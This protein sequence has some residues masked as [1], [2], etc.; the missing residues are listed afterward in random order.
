MNKGNIIIMMI[1]L[2]GAFAGATTIRDTV[3]S[4]TGGLSVEGDINVTDAIRV[5]GSLVCL[6][7]GQYC[8]VFDYVTI[9]TWTYQYMPVFGLNSTLSNSLMTS[10]ATEIT[11]SDLHITSDGKI[12]Y[13]TNS[14]D[15]EVH[16]VDPDEPSI[17]LEDEGQERWEWRATANG[18]K[19]VKE[20]V[21]TVQHIHENG[22]Y[23]IGDESDTY[24]SNFAGDLVVTDS[25]EV[26]NAS[27]FNNDVAI[28][29]DVNV[30]GNIQV[31]GTDVCL[32]DGTNCATGGSS[33]IIPDATFVAESSGTMTTG[34]RYSFGD[35]SKIGKGIAQPCSGTIKWL[36]FSTNQAM[37]GDG[38]TE[39]QVNQSSLG[40]NLTIRAGEGATQGDC[41]LAFNKGDLLVPYVL[42]GDSSGLSNY[43][44]S[45]IVEYD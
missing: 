36:S 30:T 43:R 25:F 42:T 14:P 20:D 12:G 19:I 13:K 16:I 27:Y 41:N 17:M 8:K 37:T 4:F 15:V 29:G 21:T 22:V 32:E 11:V 34:Y 45:W 26:H 24:I 7:S 23:Y 44:T 9:G 31:N 33:C 35:N 18:T 10:N 6:E 28:K 2:L 3:S 1:L 40:C 38:V 5:N 39:I